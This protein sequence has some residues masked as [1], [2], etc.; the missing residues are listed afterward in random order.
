M[1]FLDKHSNIL[2]PA[3]LGVLLVCLILTGLCIHQTMAAD[4]NSMML[5]SMS[6]HFIGTVDA[7]I[8][9]AAVALDKRISL[10]NDLQLFLFVMASLVLL[11]NTF[12]GYFE[13]KAHLEALNSL[14]YPLMNLLFMITAWMYMRYLFSGIGVPAHTKRELFYF[15]DL[16]FIFGCILLIINETSG[17]LFDVDSEGHV[18]R[19][20]YGYLFL[21]CPISFFSVTLLVSFRCATERRERIVSVIALAVMISLYLLELTAPDLSPVYLI[22]IILLMMAFSNN[23]IYRSEIISYKESQIVRQNA[24]LEGLKFQA[25]VS[26]VQPHFLY[27]ALTSIMNIQGNPPETQDAI[28]DFARYLR[29]NLNTIDTAAPIPFSKELGHIETYTNLEKLR[30]KDKIEFVWHINDTRFAIPALA[31]Q[32]MVENAVKHGVTKRE[33][34][35]RVIIVSEAVEDGHL[36]KIIDNGVGFD[37]N[38]PMPNDGRAH[39]GIDSARRR[40]MTMSDGTLTVKSTPGVGTTVTIFIPEPIAVPAEHPA[41]VQNGSPCTDVH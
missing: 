18:I 41:P 35:G 27:N 34:G 38:A 6:F 31:V 29:T 11:L 28:A 40:L 9:V 15:A 1:E 20:M 10:H 16:I 22:P 26:Q 7:L 14:T 21:L 30:F 33:H 12:T 32:T 19:G 5:V 3:E 37:V 13:G 8:V 17:I 4:H 25:L 23:Y 24:E 36:V 2:R 39:I